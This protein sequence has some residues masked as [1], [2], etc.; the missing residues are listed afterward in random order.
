MQHRGRLL[1]NDM[2]HH[3]TLL[4]AAIAILVKSGQ[5]AVL[6]RFLDALDVSNG[7]SEYFDVE[8]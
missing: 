8:K 3:G 5:G 4:C 1:L 2:K 6:H 7:F